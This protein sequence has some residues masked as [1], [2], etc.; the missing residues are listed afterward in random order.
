MGRIGQSDG[1]EDR[2]VIQVYLS[3]VKGRIALHAGIDAL[4]VRIWD[5][6]PLPFPHPLMHNG[7]GSNLFT[8]SVEH[9][10]EAEHVVE[11]VDAVPEREHG[12][13]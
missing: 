13:A 6:L 1:R 10:T 11:H 9:L 4:S 12:P 5:Q 8:R 7:E 3:K 2:A